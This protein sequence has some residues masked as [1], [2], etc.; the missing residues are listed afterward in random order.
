M[1]TVV[2]DCLH[3]GVVGLWSQPW[4]VCGSA[5]WKF[6]VASGLRWC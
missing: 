6:V 5:V 1:L 3:P 2:V 4:E